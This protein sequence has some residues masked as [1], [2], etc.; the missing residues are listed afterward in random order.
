VKT[1]ETS[2]KKIM[3][4]CDYLP[5]KKIKR[6]LEHFLT[7]QGWE[8]EIN[9]FVI[10]RDIDVTVKRG[11]EKWIIEIK[12]TKPLTHEIISS[13]VSILGRTLQRMDDEKCKYSIALPDTK[14]FR[15]LWERL[16]ILAKNRTGI[17]ALFVNPAGIVSERDK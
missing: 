6:V 4:N 16:P 1:S 8:N 10:N 15:R 5:E 14:P 13:F 12:G 17:T 2:G 9:E 11:A 3:K 7:S